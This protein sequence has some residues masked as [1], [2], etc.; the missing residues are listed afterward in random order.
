MGMAMHQ[1]AVA[2]VLLASVTDFWTLDADLSIF[3]FFFLFSMGNSNGKGE[4]KIEKCNPNDN[5]K[6]QANGTENK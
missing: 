6:R 2:L 1:L 4:S 3:L 5:L